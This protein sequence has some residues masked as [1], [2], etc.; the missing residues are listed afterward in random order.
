MLDVIRHHAYHAYEMNRWIKTITIRLKRDEHELFKLFTVAN[1]ISLTEWFLECAR[2]RMAQ[3]LKRVR[4]GKQL[5]LPG[6]STETPLKKEEA[7]QI[8]L[9]LFDKPE[10]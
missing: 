5:A 1:G 7:K 4:A 10:D 8:I 2:E 9:K 3:E 6:S